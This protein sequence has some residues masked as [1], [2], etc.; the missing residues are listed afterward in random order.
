LTLVINSD[1]EAAEEHKRLL[2]AEQAGSKDIIHSASLQQSLMYGACDSSSIEAVQ[3]NKGDAHG[4]D[5]EDS[6]RA[7]DCCLGTATDFTVRQAMGTSVF[8]ILWLIGFFLQ[9]GVAF[10]IALWKVRRLKIKISCVGHRVRGTICGHCWIT[11][12]KNVF[13]LRSG[14]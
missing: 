2:P 4:V 9:L 6:E 7:G 8:W 3:N 13:L 10:P 14:R 12:T 5:V 11:C 1:E